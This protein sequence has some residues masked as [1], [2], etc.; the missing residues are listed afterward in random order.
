MIFKRNAAADRLGLLGHVDGA[1]APLADLLEQL[2]GAD[3]LTGAFVD[4][5]KIVGRIQD[6]RTALEETAG[7]LVCL[8]QPFD[9][10][11]QDLI[12]GACLVEIGSPKGGIFL[13]QRRDENRSFGH[14]VFLTLGDRRFDSISRCAIGAEF[15]PRNLSVLA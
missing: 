10:R 13:L 11:S 14:G 2:V 15:A 6:G 8:E 9:P 5:L 1:H 12:A 7:R 4:R 3:D